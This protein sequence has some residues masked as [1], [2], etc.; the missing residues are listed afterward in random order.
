IYSRSAAETAHL[1]AEN[2]RLVAVEA[3]LR[4]RL[5]AE[6]AARDQLREQFQALSFEALERNNRQFLELAK[7]E[8]SRHQA[9]AQ[10]DLAR[11]QQAIDELVKPLR[12]SLNRVDEKIQTI[13]VARAGAY[14]L[15]TDQVKCMSDE[16]RKLANALKTPLGRGRWGEI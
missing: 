10:G 12:D 8:L 13:E 11:R 4:A 15:L 14:A 3:D 9:E 5:D 7:S 16:T 6:R 2:T 1:R